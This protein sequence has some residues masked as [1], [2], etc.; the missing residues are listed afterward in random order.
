MNKSTISLNKEE[1]E[2]DY[3]L[4]IGQRAK[5]NYTILNRNGIIVSIYHNLGFKFVRI[6]E[7]DG[8]HSTQYD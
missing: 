2:K 1:D 4:K 3:P 7:D 8:R 6:K 5:T